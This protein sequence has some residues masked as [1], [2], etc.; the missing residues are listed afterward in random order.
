MFNFNDGHKS[1]I[2]NSQCYEWNNSFSWEYGRMVTQDIWKRK[3]KK[4]KKERIE[5][6]FK[7]E[8][9]TF[10]LNRYGIRLFIYACIKMSIIGNMEM[11]IA[12][13]DEVSMKN[14]RIIM[15]I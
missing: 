5:R 4:K 13:G 10:N 7:E 15:M 8:S 1:F 6:K 12:Y 2:T 9:K 14:G 11:S 3:K